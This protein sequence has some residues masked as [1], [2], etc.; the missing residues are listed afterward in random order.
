M[1]LMVQLVLELKVVVLMEVVVLLVLMLLVLMLLVLMALMLVLATGTVG[2]HYC[3]STTISSSGCIIISNIKTASI[4][5]STS[6]STTSIS[7]TGS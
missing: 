4:C 2:Y 5:T 7:N 1:V 6:S 3:T